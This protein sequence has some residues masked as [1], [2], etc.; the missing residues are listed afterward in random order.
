L[1]SPLFWQYFKFTWSPQ[2]RALEA[3]LAS[4]KA[5]IATD[6]TVVNVEEA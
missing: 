4:S 3:E 5:A 6:V 2:V 1:V